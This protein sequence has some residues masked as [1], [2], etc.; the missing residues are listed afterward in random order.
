MY[1]CDRD[2]V[3]VGR[4]AALVSTLD[5]D[6]GPFTPNL[7]EIDH[8]TYYVAAGDHDIT[9]DDV[10]G[11]F[12]TD[13][14]HGVPQGLIVPGSGPALKI[15]TGHQSGY[16][17]LDVRVLE[18]DPAAGVAGWEAVEQATIAPRAEV[19]IYT[20]QLAV[21]DQFPDLTGGRRAEYLTVRISVRGRDA[22]AMH[23]A[24]VDPRRLPLEHHLIEAWPASAFASR[25]VLKRDQTT[26]YWE[27][28]TGG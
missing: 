21:Q 16:I 27:N 25:E 2:G 14:V 13:V 7:L 22:K 6:A 19:Q 18:S 3:R 10:L 1:H 24:R 20:D 15:R 26:R 17:T 23:H 8:Y 5:L 11:G 4:R 28:S 12:G 9:A